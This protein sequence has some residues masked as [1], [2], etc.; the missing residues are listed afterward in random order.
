MD[1]GPSVSV[2]Y[3]CCQHGGI[4]YIGLEDLDVAIIE[5]W[6]CFQ[7]NQREGNWLLTDDLLL[8]LSVTLLLI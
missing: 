2:S 8:V 6:K 1:L 5:S 3:V 7:Y 4:T